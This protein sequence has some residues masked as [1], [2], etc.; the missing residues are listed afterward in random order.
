MK[1]ITFDESSWVLV[2]KEPTQAMLDSYTKN[3]ASEY[4]SHREKIARDVFR[5]MTNAV[6]EAVDHK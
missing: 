6:T 1:T 4:K 5:I 2:P 3:Y